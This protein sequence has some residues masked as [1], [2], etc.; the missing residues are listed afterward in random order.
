MVAA[1]HGLQ[2]GNEGEGEG[3]GEEEPRKGIIPQWS[4]PIRDILAGHGARFGN[5]IE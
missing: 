1:S 4:P 5:F 2:A 3:E